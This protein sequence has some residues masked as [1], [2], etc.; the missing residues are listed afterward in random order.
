MSRRSG[1]ILLAGIGLIAATNAILLLGVAYNRKPPPDSELELTDRELL[2]PLQP[3]GPMED[4][5]LDLRLLVRMPSADNDVAEGRSDAERPEIYWPASSWLDSAKLRSL[6]FELSAADDTDEDRR[7]DEKLL[8]KDVYAVLEINGGAYQHELQRALDLNAK[9]QQLAA[10]SPA[11]KE[12]IERAQRSQQ[13]VASERTTMSRLFCID[14]GLDPSALRQKYPDRSQYAIVSAQ[15]QPQVSDLRGH[16]SVIGTLDG[17]RIDSINVPLAYREVFGV[18]QT[19]RMTPAMVMNPPAVVGG[20]ATTQ[21]YDV[22]IAWGRRLE[23]WI[24][25]ATARSP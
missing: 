1:R 16:R 7:H 19:V 23:P 22:T 21:H 24:V 10:A 14:A 25:N 5:G 11:N 17:V 9:D 12:L 2:P 3:F 8:S 20:R 13:Q 15:I 6:G 18:N 4:S